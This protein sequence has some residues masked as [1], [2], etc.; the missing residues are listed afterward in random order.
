MR[1]WMLVL[2]T[3]VAL[4]TI[5]ASNTKAQTQIVMGPLMPTADINF[6]GGGAT[7]TAT[8]SFSCGAACTASGV[9]FT[10]GSF[11]ENGTAAFTFSPIYSISS[12]N[13]TVWSFTGPST[14]GYS[15]ANSSLTDS[16]TGT[17]TLDQIISNGGATFIGTI[18]V[19]TSVGSALSAFAA[20]GDYAFNLAAEYSSGSLSGI[21]GTTNVADASLNEH[22]SI[23]STTPEPNSMLLFGTGLLAVGGI[24][25][26]RLG[27]A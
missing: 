4:L 3:F 20:G 16:L 22:S 23:A 26:R 6:I 17:I 7:D 9:V 1:K 15:F 11:V 19:T 5:G 10:S 24:L 18:H 21:F 2:A 8:A 12:T 27:L 14:V 13:G 25:R